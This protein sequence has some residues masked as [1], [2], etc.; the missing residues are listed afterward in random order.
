MVGGKAAHVGSREDD[1]LKLFGSAEKQQSTT[2]SDAKR[3]GDSWRP[4]STLSLINRTNFLRNFKHRPEMDWTPLK[5]FNKPTSA[6]CSDSD[7]E[8]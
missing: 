4:Q 1:A 3:D 5:P 8:P 6:C 7:S 2:T